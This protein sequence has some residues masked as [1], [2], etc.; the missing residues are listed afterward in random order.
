MSIAMRAKIAIRIR[1]A[2]PFLI[3][4]ADAH[5]NTGLNVLTAAEIICAMITADITSMI[6][7][8]VGHCIDIH[9]EV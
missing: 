4:I 6:L 5:V 2:W 1:G 7:S 8:Y 3:D 9:I